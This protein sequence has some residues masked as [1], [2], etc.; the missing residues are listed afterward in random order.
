ME[1]YEKYRIKGERDRQEKRSSGGGG[2]GGV[3]KG[4]PSCCEQD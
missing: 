4:R 3:E 1:G 2:V